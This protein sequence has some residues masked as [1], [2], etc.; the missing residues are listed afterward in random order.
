MEIP[1]NIQ[2]VCNKIKQLTIFEAKKEIFEE[3]Y[4]KEI[5]RYFNDVVHNSFRDEFRVSAAISKNTNDALLFLRCKDIETDTWMRA[6]P[7]DFNSLIKYQNS[8]IDSDVKAFTEILDKKLN[9]IFEYE[10]SLD[11]NH[12]I[13]GCDEY[14]T[15]LFEYLKA[16]DPAY[17][18]SNLDRFEQVLSSGQL[19]ELQSLFIDKNMN[20]EI[21]EDY[22]R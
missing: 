1:Q 14:K 6:I 21:E 15:N 4:N 3:W 17:L 19:K 5:Y 22:E 18:E 11:E 7:I 20:N 9:Y 8:L 12:N 2:S 13:I 10:F 16:A